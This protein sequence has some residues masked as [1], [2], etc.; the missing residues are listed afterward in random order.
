MSASASCA[1]GDGPDVLVLV[2]EVNVSGHPY[3]PHPHG[4][5][6]FGLTII[7][8]R[9]LAAQLIAASCWAECLQD[10]AFEDSK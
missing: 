4:A 3:Q 10:E 1:W 7:E 5:G 2:K 9:E 8:A 6:S